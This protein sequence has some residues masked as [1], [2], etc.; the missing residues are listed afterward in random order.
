MNAIVATPSRPDWRIALLLAGAAALSVA[1]VL[2]Y[3]LE[4]LPAA[5]RAQLPSMAVL[6]PLQVLQSFAI[7]TVIAWI[8][9]RV[10]ERNALDAPLLRVLVQGERRAPSSA[11]W[12]DVALAVLLALSSVAVVVSLLDP[13]LPVPHGGTPPAPT[14]LQGFFA[15]F[16]GG[17]AEELQLRLFLMSLLAWLFARAGV[18]RNRAVI[19]AIAGAAIVFGIGHLPAAAQVWPLDSWVVTRTILANALPGL[20]FGALFARHGLEAAIAAH[21]LTDIGLHVV[22]PLVAG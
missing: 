15:S 4:L 2:P 20:V 12:R 6:V 11:W 9:L 10:G 3:A 18:A 7:F 1:A 22:A 5:Q 13:R 16:Y 19:L 8:G 21:F 17:I 14:A